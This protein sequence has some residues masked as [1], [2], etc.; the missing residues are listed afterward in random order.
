M[1]VLDNIRK[2][3]DAI[4]WLGGVNYNMSQ[5][6]IDSELFRLEYGDREEY[7]N[8]SEYK[9]V[10]NV[11]PLKRSLTVFHSNLLKQSRL[12]KD[13]KDGHMYI[14]HYAKQQYSIKTKISYYK[15]Y[16][17]RGNKK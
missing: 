15:L 5:A 6:Y 16:L 17:K 10:N 8:L 7:Y 4:E 1:G 11:S 12:Y 13:T 3:S 14:S 2:M 9:D